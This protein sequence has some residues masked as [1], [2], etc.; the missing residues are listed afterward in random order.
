MLLPVGLAGAHGRGCV[1]AEAARSR[2]G[3]YVHVVWFEYLVE[4]R[5]A[6]LAIILVRDDGFVVEAHTAT[7]LPDVAVV[8]LD[9]EVAHILCKGC[10]APS[11]G[12]C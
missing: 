6:F 4:V 2:T 1:R 9:E 11:A 7:M 8:A 5:P 12:P 10:R 3:F